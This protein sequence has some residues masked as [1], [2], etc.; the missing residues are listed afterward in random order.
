MSSGQRAVMV[1]SRSV[2]FHMLQSEGCIRV[3]LVAELASTPD[4]GQNRML[5][6]PLCSSR[7][8]CTGARCLIV[9]LQGSYI[10]AGFGPRPD[11]LVHR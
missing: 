3:S 4:A 5:P 1:S 2:C 6:S 7:E 8:V 10:Y 9:I 11:L